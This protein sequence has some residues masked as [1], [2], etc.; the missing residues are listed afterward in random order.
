M[1]LSIFDTVG[2]LTLLDA[3][4]VGALHFS[5]IEQIAAVNS[6][7]AG[8]L[9]VLNSGD[10]DFRSAFGPVGRLSA[11]S[12][13]FQSDGVSVGANLCNLVKNDGFGGGTWTT[14]CGGPYGLDD[15][16]V[17]TNMTITPVTAIPEPGTALLLGLGLAGIAALRRK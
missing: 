12:S 15:F 7:L 1:D 14:T 16:T 5:G 3:D 8:N 10:A 9:S 17:N 4:Y 11:N 2:G 13:S 6:A